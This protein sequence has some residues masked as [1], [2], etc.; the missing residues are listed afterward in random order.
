MEGAD[1]CLTVN[2]KINI[3]LFLI[4]RECIFVIVG[5]RKKGTTYI[6]MYLLSGEQI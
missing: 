4:M 1:S 3:I 6:S 5:C 2:I